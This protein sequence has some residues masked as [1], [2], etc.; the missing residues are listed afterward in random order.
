MNNNDIL[1][2]LRYAL[3]LSDQE[4]IKIFR[5]GGM[6]ISP[7][8][9]GDLLKKQPADEDWLRDAVCSAKQLETFLNGLIIFKRG[10]QTLK[11]GVTPPNPFQITNQDSVNNVMLKKVRIALSLTSEDI[12]DVLHLAGVEA[13]ANEI[14]AIL[15]KEGRRNYMVCGDRYA[16]NFLKGLTIQY[17]GV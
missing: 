3:D 2:R 7:V 16:R 6:E 12:L 15:R 13:S 11:P 1:I 14:S 4:M 8:E 5:L 17:R 9:L 10:K